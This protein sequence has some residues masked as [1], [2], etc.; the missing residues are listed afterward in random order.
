MKLIH[1]NG[2]MC[3]QFWVLSN[4]IADALENKQKIGVWLPKYNLE[5]FPN[6]E[7]QGLVFYPLYPSILLKKLGFNKMSR[8]VNSIFQNKYSIHLIKLFFKFIPKIS[9]DIIDVGAYKSPFRMKY[10]T[11]I[12]KICTPES[13]ILDAVSLQFNQK[14]LSSQT[15]FFIGVHIRRGD[16]EFFENGKY[17]YSDDDYIQFM[18]KVAGIF[19]DKKISFFIASNENIDLKKFENLD[20]FKID[21][22]SA[23]YDLVG[24]SKC[25]YIFG[26]PSTYSSW[27]SLMNNV[28]LCVLSD[29]K[30]EISRNSFSPIVSNWV[31]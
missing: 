24:L 1:V 18:Q 21:S 7:K 15:D 14:K 8:I 12:K 31:I 30:I 25:D 13:D 9:F 29:L 22:T 2:Q 17:F 19:E 16:Y 4:Y 26:P 6:L 20:C 27:A 10:L 23:V 28:P 5:Q 3:N 11:E